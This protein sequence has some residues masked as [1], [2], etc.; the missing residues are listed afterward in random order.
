[1]HQVTTFLGTNNLRRTE[2]MKV[3]FFSKCSKFSVDLENVIKSFENVAGFED[4]CV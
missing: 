1:M 4:N 2:A 3:I